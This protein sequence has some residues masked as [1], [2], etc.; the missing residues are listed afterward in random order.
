LPSLETGQRASARL[1][2]PET[3]LS[4]IRCREHSGSLVL[5]TVR[6]AAREPAATRCSS[7]SLP[8]AFLGDEPA[9]TK[10]AGA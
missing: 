9:D 10:D 4:G 5:E 7:A 8:R 2:F 6:A 1:S 3:N